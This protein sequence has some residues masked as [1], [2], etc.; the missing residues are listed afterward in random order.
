MQYFYIF[1]FMI[2][3][4]LFVLGAVIMP[5]LL[6]PRSKG[7]KRTTTY[8]SGEETIGSAWVQFT[9]TYYLFALIFLAFDVEAVFLLPPAVIYRDFPGL[10]GLVEI[11][12]FVGI[13]ALGL[14]YAWSKG[15]FKWR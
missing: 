8:E 10:T 3:S 9:V 2:F 13:L 5:L 7:P 12:V 11:A 4:A 15:V 1:C 14:V 6:S